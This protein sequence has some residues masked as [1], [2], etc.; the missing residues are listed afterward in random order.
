MSMSDTFEGFVPP[1]K[2]FFHMPNE[3]INICSRINNLAELKV[4]QYVLR[5]TWGYREYDG[6]PKPITVDEFMHGRKRSDGTRMDDGTG[7][8]KPSVIQGL[9]YAI[10]HGYLICEIDN[11]DKARVIKS[12]AL[13]M[14]DT[15]EVKDL[16]PQSRGKES[17]PQESSIFTTEVKDID[18]RKTL[19]KDTLER[20]KC[21]R[22]PP[23]LHFM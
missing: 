19:G 5:H 6:T 22:L 9:K 3:W 10:K 4:V 11:A 12:Y 15:S 14:S 18:Q 16:N 23:N 21:R 20:Q 2:N 17:L 8:S 1:T 7:L 13:K